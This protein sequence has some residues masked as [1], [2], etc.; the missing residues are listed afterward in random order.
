MKF[1]QW[2]LK[3]ALTVTLVSAL[4]V[5][6]TGMVVNTYLESILA[7]FN[8]ELEGQ[9]FTWGGMLQGMLGMNTETKNI[10]TDTDT[11][12]KVEKATVNKD[13]NK[14]QGTK[15]KGDSDSEEAGEKAPVDALPVMGQNQ[16]ETTESTDQ[17]K[18]D[19]PGKD[20][21]VIVTPDDVVRK[22]DNLPASEKEEIFNILMTKLPQKEVQNISSAMENGLTEQELISIEK[23]LS[24]YL[25]QEEYDKLMALLKS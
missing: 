23:T 9:T 1:M 12:L 21:L 22:K 19:Q 8:I 14:M 24:Q 4:T 25:S 6:T 18:V 5:F 16:S 3:I 2:L 11:D 7:K 17:N 15:S 10:N 13:D 20:Q